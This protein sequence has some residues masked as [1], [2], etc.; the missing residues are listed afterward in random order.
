M[1]PQRVVDYWPEL[2]SL[3]LRISSP[4]PA[5]TKMKWQD[6][7]DKKMK[8][9]NYSYSFLAVHLY[10]PPDWKKFLRKVDDLYHEYKK[11]IWITEFAMADWKSKGKPGSNRYSDADVLNFMRAVL[12]ELEKRDY[13]ECDAW[14]G[15]GKK[16]LRKEVLRTSRLFEKGG[17]M[18]EL[19]R[20]YSDFSY[21]GGDQDRSHNKMTKKTVED[22]FPIKS[23]VFLWSLI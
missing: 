14:F 17:S 16:S 9:N 13:V 8:K 21:E 20:F 15:A 11:P 19:G 7:F 4:A 22:L 5:G 12:P 6:I 18:S 10:G 1:S 3:T 23:L 2:S